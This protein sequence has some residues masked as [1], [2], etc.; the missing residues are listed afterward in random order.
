MSDIRD[1]DIISFYYPAGNMKYCIVLILLLMSFFCGYAQEK[2]SV[3]SIR[4]HHTGVVYS[5]DV[6]GAYQEKAGVTLGQVCDDVEFVPLEITD[7]CVLD[8]DLSITVTQTDILVYDF[9]RGYRFDRN[10]KFINSIGTRGQ[11]PREFVKPMGMTV[12]TLNRWVYFL[13]IGKIVKYDYEGNFIETFKTEFGRYMLV[14]ITPG[15]FLIDYPNYLFAKPKE[16]FSMYFY[17][18][19]EKKLLSRFPCD[20]DKK[21]PGMSICFPIA[22]KFNSN[23]YLKDYW[24]DTIY[25]SDNI[26]EAN[27]YAVIQKGKFVPRDVPDRSLVQEGKPLPEDK[28]IL[29]VSGIDEFSRYIFLYANKGV[30]VFDKRENRTWMDEYKDYKIDI[31]NDLYGGILPPR[32]FGKIDDDKAV[33]Y[34]YP[35]QLVIKGN[36]KITDERYDRYRKMVEKLDPED[37]PVLMILK[38]KK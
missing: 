28:F 13:D 15:L 9:N 24:S 23:L 31:E 11:G 7:K 19:K 10:G 21:I 22:Y 27:A 8:E 35:D 36:H 20:Y 12:D 4:K 6:Y 33:M 2:V 16:R 5:I 18:E 32:G 29:D 14:L 34:A 3:P 38:L 30:F 37:N 1:F 25:V 17:S 26:H